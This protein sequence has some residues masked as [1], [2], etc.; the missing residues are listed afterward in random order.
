MSL[1]MKSDVK[2]HLSLHFRTK[3]HLCEPVS[4]PDATGFSGA[5]PDAI[6]ANPSGFGEDFV[7]EHSSSRAALVEDNSQGEPS[8]DSVGPLA[9]ATSK[10][11]QS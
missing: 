6:A 4:Q 1:T 11:V 2:N 9:P 3:I 10:S 5:D 8:L 7:R